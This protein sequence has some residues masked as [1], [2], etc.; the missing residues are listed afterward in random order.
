M[1]RENGLFGLIIGGVV[2]VVIAIFIFTGGELGGKKTVEGDDDLP[3]IA[4]T[5][6]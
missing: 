2:A 4:N 3:P 6:K 5:D 1:N